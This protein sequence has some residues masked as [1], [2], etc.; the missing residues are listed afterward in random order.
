MI[1]FLIV[2]VMM[3]SLFISGFI[4]ALLVQNTKL[5]WLRTT[6]KPAIELYNTAEAMDITMNGVKV[7]GGRVADLTIHQDLDTGYSAQIVLKQYD[8]PYV[9]HRDWF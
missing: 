8:S 6:P 5:N 1:T 4:T 9:K 3:I 2:L 7:F